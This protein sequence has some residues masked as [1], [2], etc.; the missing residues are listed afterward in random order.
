[1]SAVHALTCALTQRPT[2]EVWDL[3]SGLLY[4]FHSAGIEEGEEPPP[5]GEAALHVGDEFEQAIE[6]GVL[7]PPERFTAYFDNLR[8]AERA[9]RAV[10]PVLLHLKP[11]FDVHE[12]EEKNYAEMW[13]D[14]FRPMFVKPYWLVRASWHTPEAIEKAAHDASTKVTPSTLELVIDPGMAFGTGSHETTRACLE[15]MAH[16]LSGAPKETRAK[17]IVLDFGTGSGILAIGLKKLGVGT[18]LAVDIDPLS[19][20]A[21]RKNATE[22]GVTVDVALGKADFKALD[23][24]VANILKNTLLDFAERFHAWLKPGGFLILSGLLAEQEAEI[25]A[26]YE[27]LGFRPTERICNNNWVSLLL[28]RS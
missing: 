25:L 27:R 23:G 3:V 12:V 20:E 4:Q 14:N 16:A 22:N 26:R 11:V 18:A 6:P 2:A 15:L 9:Q 19:I 24:I 8:D 28:G 13:K 21:T 17:H 10:E 1:M 7:S 5:E